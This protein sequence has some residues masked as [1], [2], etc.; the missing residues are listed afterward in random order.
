[1]STL[2]RAVSICAALALTPSLVSSGIAQ[3][4]EEQGEGGRTG[5]SEGAFE[6]F[7]DA[8]HET[9][10]DAFILAALYRICLDEG[11]ET[12]MCADDGDDR[13]DDGE[14]FHGTL[15][16][17]GQALNSAESRHT[18]DPELTIDEGHSGGFTD[19]REE[20]ESDSDASLREQAREAWTAAIEE[21]PVE[22][23]EEISEDVFERALGWMVEGAFTESCQPA[24]SSGGSSSDASDI[25]VP[26]DYV[27]PLEEA[28]DVSGLP[29]EVLAAQ[30]EQES[31]WDE[32]AESPAGARGLTQFM[33]DTWAEWGE[34]DITDPIAAIDAQG[35][36][37][38]HLMDHVESY[39]DNDEEHIE[40]ALAA[41]N[42]G[43]GAVDDHE[44]VPPF[45]ETEHYVVVIPEMA[46]EMGADLV[47]SASRG[48]CNSN[49]EVPD[50][51]DVD[52]EAYEEGRHHDYQ[53]GPTYPILLE[54]ALHDAA[55]PGLMCGLVAFGA[56]Y[57]GQLPGDETHS[58]FGTRSGNDWGAGDTP[59]SVP[60]QLGDDHPWGG[61]IDIAIDHQHDGGMFYWSQEGQEYGREIAEFYM[62]HAEELNVYMV[63]YWE[64]QW[65]A[66]DDPKP[67]DEWDTYNGTQNGWSPTDSFGEDH[68]GYIQSPDHDNGAHR[69]HPHISF[70][71]R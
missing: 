23:A 41:Y 60:S 34:G 13:I 14:D 59:V 24:D 70:D 18:R 43:P 7:V 49:Y 67:W 15:A 62:E 65:M 33:P 26:S 52:C 32:N 30:I 29:V 10:G 1:M 22:D 8:S 63:I 64:K 48:G 50:L 44:G 61:A 3:A 68:S 51:D 40:F 36:F 56:E 17:M 69:N 4:S 39:A 21:L 47:V 58:P 66:S 2:S 37:M 12:W 38:G 20:G 9:G 46:N 55:H 71:P 35:R 45:S 5:G 57:D 31:G 6:E 11:Y 42:A 25:E 28:A 54:D 19:E 27:E 53:Q 16:E